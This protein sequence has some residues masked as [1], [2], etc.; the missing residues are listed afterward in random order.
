MAVSLDYQAVYYRKEKVVI[1]GRSQLIAST[2]LLVVLSA[3]VWMRIET[4]DLGYR[5]AAE[6][7]KTFSYDMERSELELQLSILRRPDN[8]TRMA[9]S[10]LGLHPLD[11]SQ[12]RKIVVK[13]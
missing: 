7:A 10:R 13:E 2:I 11:P 9:S 5:F 4:T 1:S 8:L 6:Q 3:R 12:A